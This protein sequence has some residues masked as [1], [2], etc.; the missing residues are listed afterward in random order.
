MVQFR[1]KWT[2]LAAHA[3]VC[4]YLV[5]LAITACPRV[6]KNWIQCRRQGPV[7]SYT[8]PDKCMLHMVHQRLQ[9]S[10]IT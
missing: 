5:F 6:N 1:I 8:Y 2:V 10:I 3:I 7:H 4:G 9:Q